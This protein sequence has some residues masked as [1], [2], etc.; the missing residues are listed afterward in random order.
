[1]WKPLQKLFKPRDESKRDT[2]L[3]HATW[4]QLT[5]TGPLGSMVAPRKKDISLLEIER[6]TEDSRQRR[7]ASKLG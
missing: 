4:L 6:L 5:D 1:M 3:S 7:N 2:L